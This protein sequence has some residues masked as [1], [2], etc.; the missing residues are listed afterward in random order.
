MRVVNQSSLALFIVLGGGFLALALWLMSGELGL[1]EILFIKGIVFCALIIQILI[2]LIVAPWFSS[3]RL[4]TH[5]GNDAE[6]KQKIS[7]ITH[8]TQAGCL[9]LRELSD[10]FQQMQ[11]NAGVNV[12]LAK[13]A[14]KSCGEIQEQNQKILSDSNDLLIKDKPVS[15]AV[16]NGLVE[17]NKLQDIL[18]KM[19]KGM[20]ELKLQVNKVSMIGQGMNSLV[21]VVRKVANHADLLAVNAAIE[22]SRAGDSGRRVVLLADDVRK[23]A[24][25]TTESINQI[26][27]TVDQ[28]LRT[29][30]QALSELQKMFSQ[31]DYVSE[32]ATLSTDAIRQS[33]EQITGLENVGVQLV[34]MIEKQQSSSQDMQSVEGRLQEV[35]IDET[36]LTNIDQIIERLTQFSED[37]RSLLAEDSKPIP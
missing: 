29:N 28:V 12:S 24:T 26:G 7:Q 34:E 9:A 31:A 17:L 4:Q 11:Q 30:Q 20:E 25:T 27:V 8:E 6:L 32:R 22:A 3:I 23:L 2:F 37:L 33:L 14:V 5:T 36:F 35:A 16:E 15:V 18:G 10:A 21:E 1:S 13:L 19:Y